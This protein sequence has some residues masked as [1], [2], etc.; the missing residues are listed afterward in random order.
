MVKRPPS[1]SGTSSGYELKPDISDDENDNNDD[2]E[3]IKEKKMRLGSPSKKS[4]KPAAKA[5]PV[6]LT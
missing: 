3:D 4:K 6:R 2:Y 5:V 1:D